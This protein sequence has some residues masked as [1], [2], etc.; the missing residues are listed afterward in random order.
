MTKT[1]PTDN[2]FASNYDPKGLTKRE[3]F[4]A[5]A[6]QGLLASSEFIYEGF[7]LSG[8]KRIK[9]AAA[10]AVHAADL[11]IHNLNQEP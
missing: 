4:A 5:I 10:T 6:L 7:P 11:L 1:N 3:Y 2:A 8:D 9:C